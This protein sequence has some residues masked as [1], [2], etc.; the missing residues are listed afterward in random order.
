M[1]AGGTF[2]NDKNGRTDPSTPCTNKKLAMKIFYV[3]TREFRQHVQAIAAAHAAASLNRVRAVNS[4]L[5]F[6][7]IAQGRAVELLRERQSFLETCT[8]APVI[9]ISVPELSELKV[10]R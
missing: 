7:K 4:Y 1:C 8:R 10:T 3:E 2:E 9:S 5:P 6:A